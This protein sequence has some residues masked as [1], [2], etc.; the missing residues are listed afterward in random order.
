M[1]PLCADGVKSGR[2]HDTTQEQTVLPLGLTDYATPYQ[3]FLGIDIRF[4][5][6]MVNL[7]SHRKFTLLLIDNGNSG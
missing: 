6:K 1:P 5:A 4:R 7:S 3:R 2:G